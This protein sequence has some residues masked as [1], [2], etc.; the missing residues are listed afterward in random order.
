MTDYFDTPEED[1]DARVVVNYANE[2]SYLE[3]AKDV[4]TFVKAIEAAERAGVLETQKPQGTNKDW[5][6]VAGVLH[7][8]EQQRYG[9][10]MNA[11]VPV[12][13]EDYEELKKFASHTELYIDW[14]SEWE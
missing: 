11:E 14:S 13:T 12:V 7:D 8:E 5:K 2:S 10:E 6:E 9:S 1:I 4:E 3:D